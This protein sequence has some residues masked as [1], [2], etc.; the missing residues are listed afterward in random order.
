MKRYIFLLLA[1]L[2]TLPMVAAKNTKSYWF[3]R[4]EEYYQKDD[5]ESCL[6]ALQAGVEEDAKDGYCWAVIAEICSKR[7]FAQY[8]RALEASEMALKYLPKKDSYWLGL[9]YGNTRCRRLP[10]SRPS[11]SNPIII[12]TASLWRMSIANSADT[13]KPR[14]NSSASWTMRR[15]SITCRP[16]WGRT[17]WIRA[18]P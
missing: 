12:S 4:A 10:T 13:T 6:T 18:T 7:A 5:Y 15:R 2:M 9:V 3:Q 11:S 16:Y 17:T 14:C 8:A 1:A